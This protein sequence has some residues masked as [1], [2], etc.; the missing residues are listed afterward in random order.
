[1]LARC[2]HVADEQLRVEEH[3][4][5]SRLVRVKDLTANAGRYRPAV[6][7]KAE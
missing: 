2:L 7:V 3:G 1:M 4:Y 6:R 5:D